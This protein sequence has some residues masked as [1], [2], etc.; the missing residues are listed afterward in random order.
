MNEQ[1]L[2]DNI[3]GVL[4]R[5]G[6]TILFALL[7][8]AQFR[9]NAIVYD[10]DTDAIAP[11]LNGQSLVDYF[12]HETE[13]LH[14]EL[15]RYTSPDE[16]PFFHDLPAPILPELRYDENP[17]VENDVNVN[18]RIRTIYERHI[19]PSI[20]REGDD[21]QYGSSA[22][23]DIACLQALSRRIHYGKFVAESK[24]RGEPGRFMPAVEAKDADALMNLITDED[25]EERVL[26][27]V[28]RKTETYGRDFDEPDCGHVL[29]PDTTVDIYRRWII[30]LNKQVQ[31][32]YLLQRGG[33]N[34]T[35]RRGRN[36]P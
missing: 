8:R 36:E 26:Q 29:E 3:R 30:P 15:R 31:V 6:E 14:A 5:I 21:Q 33:T 10:T 18:D 34:E 35:T 28:R 20:C 19:V 17:L 25:V 24:Y 27:Q 9:H 13:R 11:S 23:C 1:L 7:E 12:L 22:L 4:S 2:L 16:H 32:E